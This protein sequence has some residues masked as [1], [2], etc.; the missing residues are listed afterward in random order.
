MITRQQ[1]SPAERGLSGSPR[2]RLRRAAVRVL[3]AGKALAHVDLDR[4]PARCVL[5][6]GSARS[7]TTW[8]GE[9][10]NRHRD[11]RV[12]FEPLRPRTV[13]GLRSWEGV[14]YVR[15]DDRDPAR[16]AEMT[17]LLS[18]RLRNPW[19]DHTNT[20]LVARKRLVKEIR[21]NC[22][23]PWLVSAFPA[24]PLVLLVRHPLDV[25]ASRLRLGWDDPLDEL[26]ADER[27]VADH[28]A[29]QVD[30]LRRLQDPFVRAVAAWSVE[31]VVPLRMLPADAC[32]VFYELLRDAP[33]EQLPRV[34]RH[35]G[36]D[37]DDALGAAVKKP[38]R[39]AR[40]DGV[41]AAPP[42]APGS[43]VATPAQVDASRDVLAAFGLDRLYDVRTSAPDL[44]AL[45]GL[46]RA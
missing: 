36:Q 45:P 3:W 29:D 35:V 20:A 1:A 40:A 39:T 37:P 26:L 43:P 30:A 5:L 12:L 4:D 10:L 21:G 6:L 15:P 16:L 13:P 42:R 8:L 9:V 38:S 44:S 14:R 24:S 19:V 28:L 27:L 33:E 31:T 22:L 41:H 23:A 17:A 25:A 32:V 11:H 46:R 18:G 2:D 34:L 7:G